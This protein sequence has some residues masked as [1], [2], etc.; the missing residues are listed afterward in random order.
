MLKACFLIIVL[1]VVLVSE[2]LLIVKG[3]N[4]SVS[5]FLLFV[6]INGVVFIINR[7]KV[8]EEMRR[9]TT[10]SILGIVG[11]SLLFIMKSK[12]HQIE[13]LVKMIALFMFVYS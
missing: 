2:Y 13:F 11:I 10:C 5:L 7:S 8:K 4:S 9:L 3:K 12:A 6:I 1:L